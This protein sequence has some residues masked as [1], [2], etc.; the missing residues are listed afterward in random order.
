MA[1]QR[2]PGHRG[3][4]LRSLEEKPL[5]GLSSRGLCSNAYEALWSLGQQAKAKGKKGRVGFGENLL[6]CVATRFS[7]R[8]KPN[9]ATRISPTLC[10]V[11]ESSWV[12]RD[13]LQTQLRNENLPAPLL[14]EQRARG[15]VGVGTKASLREAYEGL[16]GFAK[17]PLEERP[18]RGRDSLQT[19]LSSVA[20]SFVDFVSLVASWDSALLFPVVA[21]SPLFP[22][23]LLLS[24]A[25]PVGEVGKL[26]KALTPHPPLRARGSM[27]LQRAPGHRG[28]ELRSLEE[29]P[30][31]GLSKRGLCS[32][33]VPARETP[34]R[35]FGR[36]LF[37]SSLPSA[38]LGSWAC[39]STS[40]PLC[41]APRRPGPAYEALTP[42]P[43]LAGTESKGLDGFAKSP[44]EE[45]PSRGRASLALCSSK[46]SPS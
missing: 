35:P 31:V 26:G 28:G 36:L 25:L 13:S 10:S 11:G 12:W 17:S 24:P 37:R 21:L 44:L 40:K 19:Q 43:S 41:K 33:S 20:L 42:R 2:A 27:A 15:L 39:S 23:G 7:L 9:Y 38:K 45:R 22:M 8:S 29:K 30:L 34:T 5:V 46:R 1:L 6:V 32:L 14:L 3:G 18:S 16:D 4:E